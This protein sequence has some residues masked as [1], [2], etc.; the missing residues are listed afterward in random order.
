M[1]VKRH[2]AKIGFSCAAGKYDLMRELVTLSARAKYN[3][4][5][6][7]RTENVTGFRTNF[8]SLREEKIVRK[9]VKIKVLPC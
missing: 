2:P 3:F 4:S 6:N 9:D 7:V 1:K 5:D 8:L